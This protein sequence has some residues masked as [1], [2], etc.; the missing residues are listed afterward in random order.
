MEKADRYLKAGTRENTRKSYRAAI[1]H[2]E[3]TWGGYLPTT[4]D[5]IV[6]YLAEYADKHAISTLKQRLAALAQ[7]HITQGFPDPTKTPNVR[8]MIKGIRVVHPAQVKQAAPLLLRHLEQAV[9]WLEAEAAAALDRGDY[10]TLL[11]HRRSVAMVLIGFWRGFRG[12]ELARL[13]IENTKAYSGEGITFFLPHTKGDRLYEGTTFQTPALTTLC[14][15]E[16]YIN[17]I[18][19]AGLAKGPVFRRLD[20]WGNLAN[21][22]IQPHSLIPMLRRVFKEAGIPEELYSTHSMRRGFATWASANGWDIKGLMS[23]VGWKDMK[24]ALRYVDVTG[25]FAGMALRN[26]Q[27]KRDDETVTDGIIKIN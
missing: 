20:R 5:G 21:K 23:Y 22:A 3:V 10:K 17:W 25:S 2:F 16:A 27:H 15:V 26:G 4:G 19:V 8:Q 11:R 24:S 7:W 14:P 12:D 6:R 18:T 1:E 9:K 13:T